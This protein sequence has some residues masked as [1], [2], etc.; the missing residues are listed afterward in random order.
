MAQLGQV[1]FVEEKLN[2]VTH[3]IGA[4]LAIAALVYLMVHAAPTG[5]PLLVTTLAVYGGFQILLYLSSA[6]MH[7]FHDMPR[8]YRVLNAMDLSAIYFL[9]AGT[10]TPAVLAG[11]GGTLGW[12][13]FGIEWGLV[14]VGL[15]L[16]GVIVR[17]SHIALDLLYLPMGWLIV[18][19]A[20]AVID[21]LGAGFM[22][23]AVLGGLLY[24]VGVIF[25]AWRRLP[26]SHMIWHL[27]VMAGGFSFFFG[28]VLHLIPMYGG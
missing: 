13:L 28:F 11:I 4:G 19:V 15:L 5:S 9:I 22:F 26:M 24:S 6:L 7:V 10:Y 17:R 18:F 14:A 20:G 25:Y 12:W 16:R 23:W 2:S 27:F 21:S 8:V 3:G 1:D